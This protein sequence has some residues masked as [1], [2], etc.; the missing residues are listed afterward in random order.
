MKNS[1]TLTFSLYPNAKG[2][3]YSLL[4]RS[5][6]LIDYGVVTIRPVCNQGILKRIYKIL[7]KFQPTL[8]IT[9]NVCAGQSRKCARIR[10][11]ID[12]TIEYAEDNNIVVVQ[13]SREQIRDVFGFS[14]AKTKHEI[15]Y[16]VIK[17]FPELEPLAP[18]IRKLWMSEDYNMGTFDALSLAMTHWYITE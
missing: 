4:D 8:L 9:E 15:A 5:R 7:D 13:Y 2:F 12:D 3:G 6:T 18:K 1:Q 14:G 16:S 10:Q 17:Q 11:L